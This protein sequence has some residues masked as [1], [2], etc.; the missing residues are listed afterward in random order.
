MKR[1]PA[2]FLAIAVIAGCVG[3][4]KQEA[5]GT[6]NGN[7]PANATE[8]ADSQSSES[9]SPENEITLKVASE[10]SRTEPIGQ[11]LDRCAALTESEWYQDQCRKLEEKGLKVIDSTWITGVRESIIHPV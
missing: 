11:A 3:C 2:G 4:G 10:Y 6:G 8:G 1:R 7:P 9:P 5:A